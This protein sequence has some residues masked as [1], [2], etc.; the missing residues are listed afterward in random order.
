MIKVDK[1]IQLFSL[2]GANGAHNFSSISFVDNSYH[3]TAVPEPMTAGI[4]SIGGCL[5]LI[6][7]RRSM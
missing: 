7:R 6:R 2:P 1:D 3:Q 5:A 4:L